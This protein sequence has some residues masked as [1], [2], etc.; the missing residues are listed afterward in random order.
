VTA[1]RRSLRAEKPPTAAL[2]FGARK[3]LDHRSP[4]NQ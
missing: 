4:A 3:G 1:A 2:R